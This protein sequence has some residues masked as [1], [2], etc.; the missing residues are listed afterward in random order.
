[1]RILR[2]VAILALA[3]PA[4]LPLRAAEPKLP[5]ELAS[6]L[7]RIYLKKE[8][9]AKV[10]GPARWLEGGKAYTTVEDSAALKGGKDIVRYD[11][12]TG[13]R[14]VLVSATALLPP[15]PDAKP[16]RDRRLR[17]VQG[18]LAP[19][20]L[21]QHQEGL[22][23]EHARRLLGP[24]AGERQAPQSRRRGARVVVDVRQVLARRKAGG[25][26]PRQQ[27]LRP[28]P[29][30]LADLAADGRRLRH[31]RQ[32]N[33]RLGVRGGVRP[34]RRLPLEPRR[35]VDRVLALRH[36]R[37]RSVLA[38]Q[39]HRHALSGGDDDPVSEGR[40]RQL[41]GEDRRRRDHRVGQ[42]AHPVPGASGRPAEYLRAARGVGRRH[43]RAHR[44]AAQPA[45][46]HQRRLARRR[47]DGRRQEDVPGQGR[48]LGRRRGRLAL[49]PGR[50]RPALAEREGRLAPRLG[51]APRRRRASAAD[52]GRIRRDRGPRRGREGRLALRH[53]LARRRDAAIPLP[54]AAS[55][56]RPLRSA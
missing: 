50:P 21:H 2:R 8:F 1:M 4:S 13:A 45:A 14:R 9:K 27:H 15:S 41:G 17:V 40:H 46:E 34:P 49:A 47:E 16:A 55:G 22:A 35:P 44:P 52:A 10:F 53:G 36:E 12:A 7:D 3:V 43:G 29:R 24:G 28:E 56:R 48:G 25:L 26:R 19:A 38:D 6:R 11:T 30:R 37:R 18:R 39:R 51:G 32:R 33:L 31:G 5:D 42:P 20:R 54:R 23:Q